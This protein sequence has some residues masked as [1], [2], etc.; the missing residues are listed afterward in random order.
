MIQ[1]DNTTV[2]ADQ[3]NNALGALSN[4]ALYPSNI[5]KIVKEGGIQ[6]LV[7][8]VKSGTWKQKQDAAKTLDSL[9]NNAQHSR[10]II[11]AGAIQPLET[12]RDSGTEGQKV[13]AEGALNKLLQLQRRRSPW[14]LLF[15]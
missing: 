4:L 8:L 6:P 15:Q 12:L 1:P 2:P 9:A 14:F 7:Q 3:K 13:F 5:N 11:D 10:L